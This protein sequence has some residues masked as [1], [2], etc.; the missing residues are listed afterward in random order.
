MCKWITTNEIAYTQCHYIIPKKLGRSEQLCYIIR[1]LQIVEIYKHH[2]HP[3]LSNSTYISDTEDKGSTVFSIP[4][5]LSCDTR[6]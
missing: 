3:S 2:I 6:V 4:M 5:A 1:L